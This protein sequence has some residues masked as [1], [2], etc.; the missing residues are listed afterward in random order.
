MCQLASW[1]RGDVLGSDVF[2]LLEPHDWQALRAAHKHLGRWLNADE[3]REL[4]RRRLQD[5]VAAP[6]GL[7]RRRPAEEE[8]PLA[9]LEPL[10]AIAAAVDTAV[11]VLEDVAAHPRLAEV[12]A[13]PVCE[14][15]RRLHSLALRDSLQTPRERSGRRSPLLRRILR[16]FAS[17]RG[18]MPG[19]V[20]LLTAFPVSAMSAALFIAICEVLVSLIHNTK[21]PKRVFMATG[22]MGGLLLHMQAHSD[23]AAMQAAGLAALLALSA[24]SAPCIRHMASAGVHEAV[25]SALKRFP[26]DTK[27]VA[28]ATG[29]LANMS[30]VA[31][32]CPA[33]QRCGV[34]APA[35]QLLGREDPHTS[36]F[37]R[38]F[39]RYLIDNLAQ[40]DHAPAGDAG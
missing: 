11:D 14:A 27:V 25:A 8:Q 1:G 38:A 32:V 40:H 28:R 5:R 29:L 22:G 33:L 26:S 35:R 15:L 18:L 6:A 13:D 30:N 17:L 10:L 23:D 3:I 31:N 4:F 2:L 16:S 36:P 9:S 39:V 19:L 20:A 24:R 21:E 12:G 34:L 7:G 37:L